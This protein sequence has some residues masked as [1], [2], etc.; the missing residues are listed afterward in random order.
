MK[1]SILTHDLP[2]RT[3]DLTA[4]NALQAISKLAADSAHDALAQLGAESTV[5]LAFAT[6]ECY[7]TLIYSA[8]C[9]LLEAAESISLRIDTVRRILASCGI[10]FDTTILAQKR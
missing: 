1:K 6:L 9:P 2:T 7:F 4:D 10:E 3:A 5:E 8:A